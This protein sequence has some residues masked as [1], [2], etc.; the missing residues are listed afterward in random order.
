MD[1]AVERRPSAALRL[2]AQ[3]QI[4]LPPPPPSTLI[5]ED[6]PVR[7]VHEDDDLIVLDKPAGLVVHPGAGHATGTLVHALLHRYG[8]LSPVGA[9]SRPGIVH[10]IDRG[11]SGLLVVAR[12]ERAHMGLAAQFAAHTVDRR[13]WALVWDK[14]LPDD[15]IVS[16]LYG[17]HP[18]ERTRFSGRVTSGKRAVT[19][20][21]VVERLGPC[22]LIECRL[23]TGRTHQ[24]RVH[25]AERGC[26]LVGDATYGQRR[27]LDR[28]PALEQLGRDLG[29]TRQ[30]L[31]AW[32]LG[33]EHPQSRA[34]LT[35]DS[36]MPPELE[37]TIAALR[38][39][40][41]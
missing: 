2:G 3:V 9:P 24:I 6:I 22:A 39:A 27:R 36:A 5:A 26:P 11:T 34:W 31:H 41:S 40:L 12:T 10:R 30:A 38:G 23:E 19:H 35:F 1:G 14:A 37:G 18:T 13:Y 15:G 8:A 17:R 25:M 33:F 20:W 28:P 21:R 29:L 16:G 32:R 7:V 4:D